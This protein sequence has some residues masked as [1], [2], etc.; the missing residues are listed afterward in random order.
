MQ[1]IGYPVFRR[2]DGPR[3]SGEKIMSLERE[4]AA[5]NRRLKDLKRRQEAIH[6]RVFTRNH[7][8]PYPADARDGDLVVTIE[9]P[10]NWE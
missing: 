7:D 6:M 2:S 5:L 10:L 1:T 4:L 9:A 3:F 8:E